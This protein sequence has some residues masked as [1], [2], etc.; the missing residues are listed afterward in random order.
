MC[1]PISFDFVP[2]FVI[3]QYCFNGTYG[4]LLHGAQKVKGEYEFLMVA[5][6]NQSVAWYSKK[7]YSSTDGAVDQ[8]NHGGSQ[9]SYI[10][11]G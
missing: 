9:Y 10:A 4:V 11:V 8:F 3:V 2:V 5:W 7:E 6:E 1:V